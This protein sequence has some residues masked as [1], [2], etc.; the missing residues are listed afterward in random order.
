MVL[1]ETLGNAIWPK[2]HCGPSMELSSFF[3]LIPVGSLDMHREVPTIIL[4]GVWNEVDKIKEVWSEIVQSCCT[5]LVSVKGQRGQLF[6]CIKNWIDC[7]LSNMECIC[8]TNTGLS[9][10]FCRY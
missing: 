2:G 4:K 8:S 6:F 10:S 1:L 9:A 3:N 5:G 7:M